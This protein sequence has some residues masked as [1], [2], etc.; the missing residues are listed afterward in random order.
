MSE[1]NTPYNELKESIESILKQ[2]HKDFELLIIDDFINSPPKF[3]DHFCSKSDSEFSLKALR[4][5]SLVES[6]NVSSD[7]I[8]FSIFTNIFF[9]LINNHE[10]REGFK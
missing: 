5:P 2:T 1:Y 8:L 9:I 7:M 4:F 6:N 10:K 3:V